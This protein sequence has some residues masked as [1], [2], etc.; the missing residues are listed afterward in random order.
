MG[1][2]SVPF[3]SF[4]NGE[5]AT[6]EKVKEGDRIKCDKCGGTHVLKCGTNDKTK[7]KTHTV[8]FYTCGDDLCLGAVNGGLMPE[9]EVV[10]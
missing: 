9:L 7:E 3:V 8:Y 4:S 5:M 6:F 10:R 1:N 2:K